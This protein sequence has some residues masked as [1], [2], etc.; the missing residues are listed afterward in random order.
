MIID[1]LMLNDNKTEFMV[2]GTW[3]QLGKV[4][5]KQLTV[6]EVTIMPVNQARNLGVHFDHNMDFRE[7]HLSYMQGR[8]FGLA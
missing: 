4:N 8:L 5:M 2:I 6:G 1:K 7:S 3:H